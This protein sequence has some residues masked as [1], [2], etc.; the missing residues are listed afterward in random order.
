MEIMTKK[1]IMY[2]KQSFA[3]NNSSRSVYEL[4]FSE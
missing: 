2:F 1:L 4:F 3:L